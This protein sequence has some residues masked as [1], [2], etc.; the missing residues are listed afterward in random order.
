V[1]QPFGDIHI[2]TRVAELE[3]DLFLNPGFAP[4]AL[5]RILERKYTLF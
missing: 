2:E 4:N 3:F 1:V 5:V